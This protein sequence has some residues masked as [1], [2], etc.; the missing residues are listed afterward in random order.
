MKNNMQSKKLSLLETTANVVSGLIISFA[1]QLLIFPILGIPVTIKQN[2]IITAIFF[3][4]SFVRGY[5]IRRLFNNLT[6]FFN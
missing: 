4:A 3:I 2:F 5:I 1:I 6:K